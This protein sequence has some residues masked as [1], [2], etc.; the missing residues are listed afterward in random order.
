MAYGQAPFS[1]KCLNNHFSG[2]DG[3]VE[4]KNISDIKSNPRAK[5]VQVPG[6]HLPG[7]DPV[8]AWKGNALLGQVSG[9]RGIGDLLYVF[10]RGSRIWDS[11]AFVGNRIRDI[12]PIP[13]PTV[14]T[15]NATTGELVSQWG[16]NLFVMPHGLTVDAAGCLWITDCGLHQVF[17]YTQESKLLLSVGTRLQSGNSNFHFCKPTSVAVSNDGSFF[18]ADGYCNSR[19]VHF[20]AEG[21]YISEWQSGD[22]K[23]FIVPHSI[24]LHECRKRVYVADRENRRIMEYHINGSL[25]SILDLSQYGE[26]Y[27]ISGFHGGEISALAWPRALKGTPLLV[28][29]EL[30]TDEL[31]RSIPYAHLLFEVDTPHDVFINGIVD[32]NTISDIFV[33]ET[34][35]VIPSHLHKFTYSGDRNSYERVD[36]GVRTSGGRRRR[37]PILHKTAIDSPSRAFRGPP[38]FRPIKRIG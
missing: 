4:A 7:V 19:V 32:G 35:A 6:A 26:V 11:R 29:Y 17:K 27:A 16:A 31:S 5:E 2:S 21:N 25:I 1:F 9:V 12:S 15:L 37:S 33:T 36:M 8:P 23:S 3:F 20:D 22:I 34:R 13:E 18:V 28:R 14:V 24:L 38:N 10:H 30:T